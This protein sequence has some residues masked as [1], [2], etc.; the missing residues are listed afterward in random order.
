VDA[1]VGQWEKDG[2]GPLSIYTCLLPVGYF[3]ANKLYESE[4]FKALDADVKEYLLHE[5]VPSYEL[6][7]VC[8]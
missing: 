6:L 2:T 7:S 3:K 8:N 1:A 5:T 4:E